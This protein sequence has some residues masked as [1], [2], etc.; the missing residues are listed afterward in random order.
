MNIY[1]KMNINEINIIHKINKE[2]EK[3]KIFGKKFVENNKDKYKIIYDNKEYELK[4]E[5]E[6][7]NKN[8]SIININY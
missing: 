5:L 3:I 7:K 4:E 6:I 8:E 2:K 1:N